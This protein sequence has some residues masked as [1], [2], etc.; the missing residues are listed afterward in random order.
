MVSARGR[1]VMLERRMA[2]TWP[3]KQNVLYPCGKADQTMRQQSYS[4]MIP[5]K[6]LS[7]V[8]RVYF[9]AFIV[10]THD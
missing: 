4:R 9:E 6:I 2:M 10:T 7:E 1:G 5:Q 3:Q 8:M